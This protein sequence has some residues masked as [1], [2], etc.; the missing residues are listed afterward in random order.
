[1]STSG[2][3]ILKKIPKCISV[4]VALFESWSS[5]NFQIHIQTLNKHHCFNTTDDSVSFVVPRKT[6]G[7]V[8]GLGKT[9]SN[10][11]WESSKHTVLAEVDQG[12]HTRFNDAKC[13]ASGRLWC[14]K[15]FV[16][17]INNWIG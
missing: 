2:T 7:Y 12:K 14:G 4:S 17:E 6:G 10:F 16:S 15:S 3:Q 1:M 13:D 9:V 5:T 11:D 8:I